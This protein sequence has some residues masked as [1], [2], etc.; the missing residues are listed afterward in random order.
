MH[1]K[2]NI[3]AQV[4]RRTLI[5]GAAALGAAGAIGALAPGR[6]RAQG[7]APWM[8]VRRDT[9]AGMLSLL[10]IVVS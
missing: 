1:S 2:D 5:Q 9:W 7:T 8:S 10:C 6:A 4:S 3:T